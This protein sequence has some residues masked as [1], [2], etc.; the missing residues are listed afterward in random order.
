METKQEKSKQLL[1]ST[2][3]KGKK[4]KGK[5]KSAFEVLLAD[6]NRLIRYI[7]VFMIVLWMFAITY[8][9]L[10]LNYKMSVLQ[11]ELE[12]NKIELEK[13]KYAFE[14]SEKQQPIEVIFKVKDENEKG[15]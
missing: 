4:S 6:R 14:N 2:T 7:I 5:T 15:E 3:S 11:K 1:K 12:G 9:Q 13:L 10:N 8:Q